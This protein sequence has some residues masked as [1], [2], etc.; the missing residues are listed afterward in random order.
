MLT[1]SLVLIGSAWAEGAPPGPSAA[2]SASGSASR[3]GTNPPPYMYEEPLPPEGRMPAPDAA[4]P[5]A[6]PK[7]APPPGPPGPPPPPPPAYAPYYVYEPLP[8]PPMRHRTPMN[9]LWLGG[10]GGVMFPSGALYDQIDT[11]Q[12]TR[13]Y[14]VVNPQSWSE[15]A[16]NGPAF[17]LDVGGRFSRHYIIY[18]LWEHA[19]LGSGAGA[20]AANPFQTFGDPTSASTDLAGV[21]FR[22]SSNPDEVGIV[23]DLALGYR[24]FRE[25]WQD[26]TKVDM[27]GL[28]ETRIGIGADIRV[29]DRLALSPLFAVSMGDFNSRSIRG[30]G[31]P[32][33]GIGDYNDT[34]MAVTLTLGIHYDLVP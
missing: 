30:P 18:G 11:T 21:G 9:S 31:I 16:G 27:Q 17:E 32:S 10:R 22:W 26:G 8:P 12:S 5:K 13:S 25:S 7:P 4:P 6:A 28:G 24:W 29:A 20:G 34:H 14:Q 23:L 2:P 15:L 1:G 19:F 33:S 3:P